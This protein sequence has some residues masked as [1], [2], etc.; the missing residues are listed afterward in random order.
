MATILIVDDD[1]FTRNVLQTI[2]TQDKAFKGLDLTI[3]TACD[4]QDG[5][6]AYREHRPSIVITDLLMPRLDGFGLCAGI[7]G[8]PGG[9]DV[10]IMVTS[11]VYRDGAVKQRLEAEYGAA[12]F[13]KPYQVKQL[14]QAVA[15]AVGTSYAGRQPTMS[16]AALAA[17]P[18]RARAGS[19][20][21]TPL[22]TLLFELNDTIETGT[23]TIKHG[24]TMK[25]IDLVLGHPVAATSNV[26]EETLGHFLVRFGVISADQHQRGL[27]V[28]SAQK[29]RLGKALVDDGVITSENL[30]ELLR[31]QTQHRVVEALTWEEGSWEFRPG[32]E[33]K[34]ASDP[35]DLEY[36][37]VRGLYET[38]SPEQAHKLAHS[39]KNRELSLTAR[40][41][42]LAPR[43]K[44]LLGS[45]FAS[46]WAE[47]TTVRTMAG[48]ATDKREIERA[49]ATLLAAGLVEPGDD[50]TATME[51]SDAA[52]VTFG[53]TADLP[54][55]SALSERT[56]SQ[57]LPPPSATP[58]DEGD[59]GLYGLLF[60]E[61]AETTRLGDSPLLVPDDAV[62]DALG[63]GQES[64]VIDVAQIQLQAGGKG[65]RGDSD[66]ARRQLIDEYLRVNGLDHYNIL[67][68]PREALPAEISGAIAE[69]RAKF[70]LEF[71]SRY[72]LGRD[73]AKLEDLHRRYE[74]ARDVLLDDDRRAEYDRELAGDDPGPS[75]PSLDAEIAYGAAAQLLS[76]GD[77]VSA[78]AKL[79]G[80][81]EL[82]PNE[83][84][85]HAELGWA[86][87]LANGSTARAA[88]AAR[89]H[90]ND[91]LRLNPDHP[92]AHEYKGAITALLG[93]DD[94]EAIFH[95][96][97]AL[98]GDPSRLAA[99]AALERCWRRRGELRPLER[100]YRKL[101][102]R[103]ASRG[104][105]KT[106]SAL[107]VKLGQLYVELDDN[108]SARVA[109]ESALKL[110]PN[111]ATIRATLTALGRGRLDADSGR[112]DMLRE[113]WRKDPTKAGPGVEYM[114][115]AQQAN[116]Q[117]V[118]FMA[119]SALIAR[120][121]ADSD[122]EDLYRRY[123]PRFVVR[124]HRTFDQDLWQQLAHEN[125]NSEIGTFFDLLSP[126]YHRVAAIKMQ[127]LEIDETT[128]VTDDDLPTGFVK[129]R[130]Y[131]AHLFGLATPVV[132][133]RPDFGHE[134]HVGAVDPPVL[135]VGEETLAAPERLELAYRLGR[136]MTY[137]PPGRAL[138]GSHPARM[139]KAGMLAA[140]TAA[141]PT[142]PVE[143]PS[144]MIEQL[145]TEIDTLPAT[146]RQRLLELAQLIAN[147]SPN[148][149]LSKWARSLARTANRAG[150]LVC[151]D[152]PA[153]TR[154]ARD[155]G[156]GSSLDE[157][158]DWALGSSFEYLRTQLGTSIEV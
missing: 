32:P 90:L 128:A 6:E 119:A 29:I 65:T 12:L 73:L 120:G 127:D 50:D 89:P 37:I 7:R 91:A 54:S 105:Q 141:V 116:C 146:T 82:A 56:E 106:T 109:Y 114:R 57:R 129:M 60:G 69:R 20:V 11:G 107:W 132:H 135:I 5:L 35:L 46:V 95:L 76:D 71:Y 97:R 13:A 33:S 86:R 145:R 156:A 130:G 142:A 15:E 9:K 41:T 47:G 85:Y 117:D 111:D 113:H 138:G 14:T 100:Q 99:L 64:G 24:S 80:A 17:Q 55:V 122:A 23:L 124:A 10:T 149:N 136:A 131:V 104:T 139:L 78:I 8:E 157:L 144:G 121:V 66:N 77:H 30:V 59:E 48:A 22:P 147:R 101:I 118:A 19:L 34:S 18:D 81:V 103:A 126:A 61:G 27:E 110:M 83:P 96:E 72:D 53:G 40:G 140:L 36:V 38:T 123:R 93:T 152:L 52:T 112:L 49:V 25:T 44:G 154:F 3:L 21:D 137:L 1:K 75:A 115:A 155:G 58:E 39:I 70:S 68:V 102:H 63:N 2:F 153:A 43:L 87:F 108:D 98:E 150:L 143:D 51:I 62:P 125:D 94:V 28:A 134:I 88:D 26:R 16:D 84:E 45:V 31:A 4:G 158:I 79:E 133:V 151:G 74:L 148:I 67:M 92:R 42:K